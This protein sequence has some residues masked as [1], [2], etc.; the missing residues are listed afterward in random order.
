VSAL[1]EL[2]DRCREL[3]G[4]FIPDDSGGWQIV[5]GGAILIIQRHPDNLCAHRVARLGPT[6]SVEHLR[7]LVCAGWPDDE[8]NP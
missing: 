1:E 3:T 4:G 5:H 7:K 2:N 6:L 8:I